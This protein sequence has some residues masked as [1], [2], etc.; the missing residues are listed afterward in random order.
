MQI[1]YILFLVSLIVLFGYLAEWIFKSKN[2]PD[3]II[4]ISLGF[5]MGP[6]ALNI[7]DLDSLGNIAPLFTTFTLLFLL[8]DGALYIDLKSFARGIGSG[9]F[10]GCSNFFLSASLIT[11]IFYLS[12]SDLILSLMLGFSLGGIS[13]AFI[14]PIL[15]QI[16]VDKRIFSVLTLESALTDVLSIVLAITMMELKI[17]NVITVKGILSQITSKFF[18]ASVLGIIAG[19]L[20]IFLEEKILK[21]DC[22]YVMTI[23]YVVQLYIIT[24]YLGGNGAIAAMCFGIVIANSKILV[25]MLLWVRKPHKSANKDGQ[26]GTVEKT[27]NIVTKR[28]RMF[29]QEISFFLKTFFFVYIGLLLNVK[30][31][32]AMGIGTGIALSILLLRNFTSLITRNFKP[33]DRMLI[34]SLFARGIAPA[35]IITMALEKKIEINSTNID[36]VYIVVTATIVFSSIRIFF[37][38]TKAEKS[39]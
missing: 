37:Y 26:E 8:F 2:V 27:P 35:A 32:K 34:N 13:S 11:W 38:K 25:A 31:L 18:V 19:F 36:I 12:T 30:N 4:L 17:L 3:I 10:I 6:N 23:A 20:W 14:I 9:I 29:Y 15:K 24:E 1:N 33:L 28:E 16:E 7:V 22:N 5:I 39:G 21:G